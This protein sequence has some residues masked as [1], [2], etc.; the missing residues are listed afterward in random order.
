MPIDPRTGQPLPYPPNEP[1]RQPLRNPRPRPITGGE[2]GQVT[3]GN[4]PTSA[5]LVSQR[6][7][8]TPHSQGLVAGRD[9]PAGAVL[10]QRAASGQ[11]QG[12]VP[13]PHIS[14][15]PDGRESQMI[16][17]LLSS[18]A[19]ERGR[20]TEGDVARA[21]GMAGLGG[22]AAGVGGGIA[23]ILS[24]ALGTVGRGNSNS[25]DEIRKRIAANESLLRVLQQGR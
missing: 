1:K 19:G 11:G 4:I 9:E 17:N 21:R 18:L 10:A 2:R 22:G 13:G 12:I 7:N 14:E 8:P 5:D 3:S 24:Q 23:N 25:P 15:V 6:V 20:F 16:E